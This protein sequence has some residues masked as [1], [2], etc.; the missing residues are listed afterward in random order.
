MVSNNRVLMRKSS[1]VEN[2][3]LRAQRNQV[4]R[5]RNISKSFARHTN[6]RIRARTYG[7]HIV[8]DEVLPTPPQ[9]PAPEDS[10]NVQAAAPAPAPMTTR[11]KAIHNLR[12]YPIA[13]TPPPIP[14]FGF[15]RQETLKAIDPMLEHIP[16]Q[17]IRD[18]LVNKGLGKT[19]QRVC[20]GIRAPEMSRNSVSP[21]KVQAWNLETQMPTHMC[22]VYSTANGSPP[23]PG[24]PGHA[25]IYPIHDIVM[26]AYCSRWPGL[27]QIPVTQ[28]TVQG[29]EIEIPLVNL[30]V[31][32]PSS[33]D[34]LVKYLYGQAKFTVMK[35]LLPQ[36]GASVLNSLRKELW[37]AVPFGHMLARSCS[38]EELV[39][40]QEL[41]LGFRHNLVFLG[42]N[43]K[44]LWQE[45][46]GAWHI[47][48]VALMVKLNQQRQQQAS[49]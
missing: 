5:A 27:P 33:F 47:L 12:Y 11:E 37:H 36:V 17:F 10:A 16:V 44:H 30:P 32:G 8:L 22:A 19:M 34:I 7:K 42:I 40:S 9:T 13:L 23:A 18:D 4:K 15:I 41:T 6:A 28:P 21:V 45:C 38:L 43:D 24:A 1:N 31:P 20:D 26:A 14:G 25:T 3:P 35:Q 2:M 49:A 46:N 39:A 29:Q 48:R